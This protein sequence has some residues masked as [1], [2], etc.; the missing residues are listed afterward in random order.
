MQEVADANYKD[1]GKVSVEPGI[2]PSVGTLTLNN[3]WRTFTKRYEGDQRGRMKEVV[4]TAANTDKFIPLRSWNATAG[5]PFPFPVGIN[6]E[7]ASV[8][9]FRRNQVR[10]RGGTEMI[11]FDEWKAEDTE[12]FHSYHL[13]GKFPNL[14]CEEREQPIAWGEQSA[15]PDG[16]WQDP[17]NA[18]LGGSPST[19]P[20]AHNYASSDPWN[21]YT[22]LPSYYDLNDDPDHGT[23]ASDGKTK[24][25]WLDS[26]DPRM[27]LGV[28]VSRARTE[29]RTSDANSQIKASPN[30]RI[31]PYQSNL[32]ASEMVAVSTSEVYFERPLDYKDNQFGASNFGKPKEIGSLFNPYWQV[33]LVRSNSDVTNQ[34]IRQ[35]VP[36]IFP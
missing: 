10:R 29:L 23:L 3:D 5:E 26:E 2:V 30:S 9:Q 13:K 24:I 21:E 7:C 14:R 18:Y 35:G 36:L 34:Q 31:N 8:F 1:D 20:I 22:G 17:A 12:S 32:A 4:V 28:R 16:K 11:G 6:P 19:N 25:S 27:R 15:Y 33:R